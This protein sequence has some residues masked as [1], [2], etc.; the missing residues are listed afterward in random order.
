MSVG[1]A[2]LGLGDVLLRVLIS[3][4]KSTTRDDELSALVL[5][6]FADVVPFDLKLA[7]GARLGGGTI[8]NFLV[9]QLKFVLQAI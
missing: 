4:S 3:V 5:G 8:L 6:C 1:I 2:A 9:A 7:V